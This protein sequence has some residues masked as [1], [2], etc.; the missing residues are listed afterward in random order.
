[1]ISVERPTLVRTAS[2]NNIE[3]S[4]GLKSISSNSSIA[5]KMAKRDIKV[6][7][8]EIKNN[9]N[10][11]FQL[12]YNNVR[13]VNKSSSIPA[14]ETNEFIDDVS[15]NVGGYWLWSL[16]WLGSTTCTGSGGCES[17]WY[18]IGLPIALIN[19]LTASGA[20]S[21]F[22]KDLTNNRLNFTLNSGEHKKGMAYFKVPNRERFNLQ[23]NY[24]LNGEEKTTEIEM[25]L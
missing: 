1:M 10:S 25:G 23:I 6:I 5:E 11:T 24:R 18:P 17:S 7:E 12:D 9:S 21:D 22:E 14:M 16:L 3:F 20:N 15:F 4:A 19:V 2:D 13:L 8:V